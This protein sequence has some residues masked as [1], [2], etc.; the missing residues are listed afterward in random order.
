[1]IVRR[2]FIFALLVSLILGMVGRNCCTVTS[3]IKQDLHSV[4][5]GV[6][7]DVELVALDLAVS[8]S[9]NVN[10]LSQCD[11][12]SIVSNSILLINGGPLVPTSP[13]LDPWGNPYAIAFRGYTFPGGVT[14]IPEEMTDVDVAT[15]SFGPNGMNESGRG[16][17]I[18]VVERVWASNPNQ[19][20]W[21]EDLRR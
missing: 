12:N 15:W 2:P 21:I 1:M 18:L 10:F 13:F 8:F 9:T 5:V 11:F 20:E 17:D 14:D 7:S 3:C 6:K 19:S 16:D 4:I